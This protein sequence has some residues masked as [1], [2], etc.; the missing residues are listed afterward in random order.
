MH[1]PQVTSRVSSQ[2]GFS[3]EIECYGEHHMGAEHV[4]LVPS[5]PL[6]GV[7]RFYSTNGAGFYDSVL[8]KIFLHDACLIL[9]IDPHTLSCRHTN[10]PESWYISRFERKEDC[11]RFELYSGFGS[12]KEVVVAYEDI[13]WHSGLGGASSG[14]FPSAHVLYI[15]K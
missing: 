3:V 8:D 5:S 7:V 9:E 11:F 13:P 15:N 12:H 6:E 4:E 10:R 1:M 2:G 14:R